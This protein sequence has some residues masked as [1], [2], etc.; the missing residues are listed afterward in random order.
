MFPLVLGRLEME[1]EEVPD[2]L[3]LEG[4]EQVPNEV[5][6]EELERLGEVLLERLE[7]ELELE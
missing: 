4:L 3:F 1:L 2:E 5:L 6:L 7:L